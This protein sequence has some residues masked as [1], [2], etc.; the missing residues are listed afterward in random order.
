MF[1]RWSNLVI[2][3]ILLFAIMGMR[4]REM[5]VR[6]CIGYRKIWEKSGI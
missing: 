5:Q 3:E 4:K 2:R 1:P 6:M